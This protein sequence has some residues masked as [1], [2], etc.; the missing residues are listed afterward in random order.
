[1]EKQ[2]YK[3]KLDKRPIDNKKAK[4][5]N[6][7]PKKTITVEFYPITKKMVLTNNFTKQVKEVALVSSNNEEAHNFIDKCKSEWGIK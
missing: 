5:V 3:N 7:E 2:P 4:E 6:I 1:M